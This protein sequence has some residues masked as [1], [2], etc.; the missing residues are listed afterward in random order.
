MPV[1]RRPLTQ[2][3]PSAFEDTGILWVSS[4]QGSEERRGEVLSRL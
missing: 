3:R 4:L 2:T 1:G